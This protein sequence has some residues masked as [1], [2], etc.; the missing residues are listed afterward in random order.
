M[1]IAFREWRRTRPFW[2]GLLI[3]LGAAEILSTTVLSLGPAFRVGLGGVNAFVGVIITVLLGVCGLLLWFSPAQWVFYSIVSVVLALATFNTINYGGF[4]L[5]MLFGVV[6]GAMAFAWSRGPVRDERPGQRS[7][8]APPDGN[9][10]PPDQDG[11]PD[12]DAPRDEGAQRNLEPRL[13]LAR[14]RLLGGWFWRQ[15][16]APTAGTGGRDQVLTI[17]AIP[18]TGLLLLT[19]A[20][21]A[22][23]AGAQQAAGG[24]ARPSGG[25]I[26]IIFC[27]PTKSPT[28][29]PT[30]SSTSPGPSHTPSPAPGASSP[31]GSPSPSATATVTA[32]PKGNDKLR[33]TAAPPGLVASGVPAVLTAGAARLTGLAYDGVT[34]IPRSSG[35]PIAMMKFTLRSVIL[36]GRPTLTIHQN[37]SVATTTTSL[38]SLR[39]NVVLYAA[40]L[41]G[42]LLGAHVTITPSSPLSLVVRLLR[43]LTQ[44]LT[45]TMTHVVTSQ[46]IALAAT[47]QWDDYHISVG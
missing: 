20:L 35:G 17:A 5:G 37:G 27:P 3:V 46:P 25:C 19:P 29:S 38:L 41:S 22:P 13:G 45:T 24:L 44:G 21:H 8:P 36:T 23:R 11:S 33:R 16:Q 14:A 18:L 2:G 43:P 4:F 15:G 9:G 7:E 28:P 1:L 34:T 47:S 26:L 42:D 6:G 39:G 40:K 31:A 12:Q 10:D 32:G 30:P